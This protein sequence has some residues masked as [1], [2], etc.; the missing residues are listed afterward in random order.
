MGLISGSGRLR[1][2]TFTSVISWFE[3]L[4]TE[5]LGGLASPAVSRKE[6]DMIE[7]TSRNMLNKDMKSMLHYALFQIIQSTCDF[8]AKT[9]NKHFLLYLQNSVSILAPIAPSPRVDHTAY[10]S[11]AVMATALEQMQAMKERM[12]LR[13]I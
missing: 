9:L 2:H 4:W 12:R 8:M 13:I 6:P 5:K 10:W 1:G 3:N 11:Q 7:F